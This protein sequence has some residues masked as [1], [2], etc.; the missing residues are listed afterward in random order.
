MTL[1]MFVVQEELVVV[2]A[3]TLARGAQGQTISY[4]HKIH[5]MGGGICAVA[6]GAANILFEWLE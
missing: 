3:D 5:D 2:A 4:N 6:T 1:L